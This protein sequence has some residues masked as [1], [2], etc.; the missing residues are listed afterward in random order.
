MDL[1]LT[2]MCI[3]RQTQ[4]SILYTVTPQSRPPY[5]HSTPS[6]LLFHSHVNFPG[7]AVVWHSGRCFLFPGTLHS[8]GLRVSL[9]FHVGWRDRGRV[10]WALWMIVTAARNLENGF[11][12]GWREDGSCLLL[13]ELTHLFYSWRVKQGVLPLIKICWNFMPA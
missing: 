11:W 5:I 9:I 8:C 1:N 7:A 3:N 2:D 6:A 13:P 12:D 10:L 4:P